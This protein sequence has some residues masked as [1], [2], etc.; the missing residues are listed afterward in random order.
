M[1]ELRGRHTGIFVS[2]KV[3][4]VKFYVHNNTFYS[5]ISKIR[6]NNLLLIKFKD[7]YKSR[8]SWRILLI[9]LFLSNGVMIILKCTDNL[10]FKN[11]CN[12]R[13]SKNINKIL[14][15]ALD[16]NIFSFYKR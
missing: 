8:E 15:D 16:N 7:K 4:H 9:L 11:G 6:V 13:L 10:L 3:Q 12:L 1:L 2:F 14:R 5:I